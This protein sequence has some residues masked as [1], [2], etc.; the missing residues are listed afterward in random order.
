MGPI[1]KLIFFFRSHY[2]QVL[3]EG[4]YLDFCH[5][6]LVIVTSFFPSWE[7]FRLF[8]NDLN[9]EVLGIPV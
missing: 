8:N 6:F 2:Y 4:R 9:L 1:L 7:L 3:D 5:I